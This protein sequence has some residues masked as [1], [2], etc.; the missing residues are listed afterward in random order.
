VE[1]WFNVNTQRAIRRG[2][3]RTVKDLIANLKRF[4]DNCNSKAKSFAWTATADSILEKIS[5]LRQAISGT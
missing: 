2:S 4:V 3:F 5:R 1:I